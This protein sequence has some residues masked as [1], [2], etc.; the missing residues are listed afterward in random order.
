MRKLSRYTQYTPR[1]G[2]AICARMATGESLRSI[3]QSEGMPARLTVLKW[4]RQ[5]ADFAERYTV[6]R[7]RQ[8]ALTTRYS[9]E[10]AGAVCERIMAGDTLRRIGKSE[11]MPSAQALF[12][13]I[14]R[15]PEFAARYARAKEVQA[16]ILADD[17][18][19]IADDLTID[20]IR[21]RA[22]ID[23]R[24]WLA[25]RFKPL[26]D[27]H[28]NGQLRLSVTTITVAEVLTGPLQS[29]NDVLAK[30]YKAVLQ[31]W[32]PIALDMEIAES[33]ARLRASLRL[34]LA[35]AVQLASALSVNAD[36]LA[37]YDRDFSR[38]RGMRI[39]S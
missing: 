24:K 2:A 3:C 33:A 7:Q 1:L 5:H 4:T 12:N 34:K 10:L 39:I 32:Q 9:P 15:Y 30:R 22:Q 31:S 14:D 36:A 29:G 28:D 23:A 16:D 25:A 20:P 19:D 18:L 6:A 17:I 38:V 26:F 8:L 13:W 11:G 27:A 35:D 37:T 21:Q